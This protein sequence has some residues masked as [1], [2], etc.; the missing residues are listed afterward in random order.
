VSTPYPV[1]ELDNPPEG[2]RPG[3]EQAIDFVNT[4]GLSRGKPFEDLPSAGAAVHW[5]RHAGFLS[6][7]TARTEEERLAEAPAEGEAALRRLRQARAGLRELI[8]ALAEE[9]SPR[10]AAVEAVNASLRV[11][12][13]AQLVPAGARLRIAY[14]RDGKPFDQALATISRAIADELSE[15]HPHRFRVCENDTCRWAFYDRSRPG[16]RRWCEMSSCGNRMKAAR[17]R[18]RQRAHDD[19]SAA[20]APGAAAAGTGAPTVKGSRRA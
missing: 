11:R 5:L 10:R 12:E 18:A 3:L 19:A 2:P 7:E 9:R 15:G 4:T 8:D 13:T 1:I 6:A 17:H 14:R 20:P 16:T